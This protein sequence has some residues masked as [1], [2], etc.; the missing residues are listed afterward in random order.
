MLNYLRDKVYLKGVKIA[1]QTK[2]DEDNA[3]VYTAIENLFFTLAYLAGILVI[4]NLGNN[5][6]DAAMQFQFATISA[7]LGLRIAR[8]LITYLRMPVRRSS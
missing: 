6:G 5:L 3:H 7:F 8:Y 2:I 1:L 4:I